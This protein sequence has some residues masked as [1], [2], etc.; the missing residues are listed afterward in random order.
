MSTTEELGRF[1]GP[2]NWECLTVY[3]EALRDL[4]PL[5]TLC[6]RPPAH[7]HTRHT[8]KIPTVASSFQGTNKKKRAT[9]R[10]LQQ[11]LAKHLCLCVSLP[12]RFLSIFIHCESTRS[13]AS[14]KRTTVGR[15]DWQNIARESP[16]GDVRLGGRGQHTHSLSHFTCHR[17]SAGCRGCCHG[18]QAA[19]LAAGTYSPSSCWPPVRGVWCAVV[20]AVECVCVVVLCRRYVCADVWSLC[21]RGLTRCS[22]LLRILHHLHLSFLKMSTIAPWYFKS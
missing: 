19:R 16:D 8:V 18:S 11:V 14:A 3:G 7:T 1:R 15:Q 17:S 2:D 4:V 5:R 6:A 10:G 12:R 20:H 22:W 21:V 9:Q 13:I